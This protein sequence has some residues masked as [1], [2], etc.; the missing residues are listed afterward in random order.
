M[1]VD[2]NKIIDEEVELFEGRQ[3]A[4]EIKAL[5]EAILKKYYTENQDNLRKLYDDLLKDRTREVKSVLGYLAIGFKQL[6]TLYEFND[7][8]EFSEIKDFIRNSRIVV[9]LK[10]NEQFS[11]NVGGFYNPMLKRVVCNINPLFIILHN[12]VRNPQTPIEN[13]NYEGFMKLYYYG[14]NNFIITNLWHELQHANDDFKSRGNY[15]RTV[16]SKEYNKIRTSG[17]YDIDGLTKEIYDLYLSI[18]HEYWARLTQFVN[19][20]VYPNPNVEFRRIYNYF[21]NSFKGYETLNE[22]DKRKLSKA[23]YGYYLK[24]KE[25]DKNQQ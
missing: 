10:Y 12:Y 8:P 2:I 5:G 19:A 20:H 6:F 7:S 15:N 25:N 23:L 1:A 24:A 17:A 16:Q 22:K 9:Q 21:R 11:A 18:P 14:I 4:F 3:D 13:I